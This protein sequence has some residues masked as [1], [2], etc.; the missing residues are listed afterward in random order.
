MPL[1]ALIFTNNTEY[2]LLT[3]YTKTNN[4]SFNMPIIWKCIN[5][6]LYN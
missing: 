4:K 5:P 3:N 1:I 6:P 2:I